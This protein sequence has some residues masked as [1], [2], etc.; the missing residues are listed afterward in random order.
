MGHVVSSTD[1][2]STTL[3]WL[4]APTAGRE[5]SGRRRAASQASVY[6]LASTVPPKVFSMKVLTFG[7]R[8]DFKSRRR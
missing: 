3:G 7:E 6:Q 4:A 2:C 8:Y 1:S 5:R